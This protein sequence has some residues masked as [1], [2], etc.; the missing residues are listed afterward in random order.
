MSSSPRRKAKV[1]LRQESP[2][3]DISEA[4]VVHSKISDRFGEFSDEQVDD[5]GNR[6]KVKF[7]KKLSDLAEED[8]SRFGRILA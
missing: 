4:P 8:D 5:A 3:T 1:E 2:V 6:L 7:H